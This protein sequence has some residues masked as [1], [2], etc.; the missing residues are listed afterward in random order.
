MFV[1]WF[2]NRCRVLYL[3]DL[4]AYAH[5]MGVYVN[6][7]M[8]IRP[9]CGR[10]YTHI[11]TCIHTH[12]HIYTHTLSHP[13]SL[14][15]HTDTHIHTLPAR[16][17]WA[18]MRS[19]LGTRT[20]RACRLRAT[21]RP[22]ALD[23]NPYPTWWED[24]DHLDERC[25]TCLRTVY[26]CVCMLTYIHANWI[27]VQEHTGTYIVDFWEIYS[28]NFPTIYIYVCMPHYEQ[29]RVNDA[30]HDPRLRMYVYVYVYV[31]VCVC[32]HTLYM[33]VYVCI[34]MYATLWAFRVNDAEHCACMCI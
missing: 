27:Q 23:G 4:H 18:N 28:T 1:F 3:R 26:A 7:Y 15:T 34:C 29:S 20:H 16:V 22:Y 33:Y 19:Y 24:R 13:L 5:C 14:N 25:Q 8:Y 31:C 30:K 32:P 2:L 12:T 6:V 10:L 9:A 17:P 21:Q 11:C